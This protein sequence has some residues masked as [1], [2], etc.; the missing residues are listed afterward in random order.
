MSVYTEVLQQDLQQFLTEY[1]VGALLSHQ[2]ISAGVENTNYFVN[3]SGGQYVLTLFENINHEDLP[4]CLGLTAFLAEHGMPC[5]HPIVRNNGALFDQLNGR[6]A[7]LVQRLKGST[8]D[9]PSLFQCQQIADFMGRMHKVCAHFKHQRADNR[10]QRWREQ[11]ATQIENHLSDEDRQL[12]RNEIIFQRQFDMDALPQ[13]VIHADLFRD[14][15]LFDGEQ[16]A[17]VIDFYNACCGP[18]LYD[19]AILVNDWCLNADFSLNQQKVEVVLR[20]YQQ[21]R[22]LTAEEKSLWPVMLRIAAVRFWLSRW[23][24]I[25]QP[26]DDAAL[27][28]HKDPTEYKQILLDRQLLQ[29]LR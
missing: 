13:G 20:A 7:T 2:G 8:I 25:V 28:N 26:Q 23:I 14:N 10:W 21:Q 1:S 3:T 12:L 27:V 4:F 18:L 24:S 16:L 11:A 22:M 29:P 17:G 9:A 5:A 15:A 6:P 19:L